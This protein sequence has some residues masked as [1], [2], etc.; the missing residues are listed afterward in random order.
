MNAGTSASGNPGLQIAWTGN[1]T[2]N[3]N[4]GVANALRTGVAFGGFGG[5]P[6]VGVYN[7]SGG[8]L[9]TARV[10]KQNGGANATFNFNGGTLSP[11]ASST[12]FL[13]GLDAANVQAGGAVFD[14]NGSAITVGQTLLNGVA[15]TDGGLTLTDSNTTSTGNLTLT[16]TNTYNGTTRVVSTAGAFGPA[17]LFL[18]NALAVQNSTVQMTTGLNNSVQF[19]GGIGAFTF[20]G[21]SG[22]ANLSLT[23]L[24]T[25]PV[26]LSVGNNNAETT[27]SG[28][29][30]TA[31]DGA[32]LVKIGSGTL[33]LTGTQLYSGTTTDQRRHALVERGVCARLAQQLLGGRRRRGVPSAR[34]PCLP[35][36]APMPAPCTFTEPKSPARLGISPPA[37]ST[38]SM[39]LP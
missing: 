3:Q 34:P 38:R 37:T 31:A 6:Q 15:G 5:G 36:P 17:T 13:Q 7:L 39:P 4:G 30:G 24:G 25:R 26:T 8:I 29:L 33:H 20:G 16:G 9:N 10:F 32:N 12:N 2:F 21:L 22:S 19:N 28:T 27:Y 14:T 23:D 1:S 18:G 11:T 35:N